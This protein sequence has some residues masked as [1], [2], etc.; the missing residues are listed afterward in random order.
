MTRLSH[1][2]S[3]LYIFLI[4]GKCG[5]KYLFN[6]NS[7]KLVINIT[8]SLANLNIIYIKIFQSICINSNLFTKEQIDYLNK[9]TDNV[10]YSS[11][12]RVQFL[13]DFSDKNLE[14]TN[15]NPINSGTMALVYKGKLNGKDIVVKVLRNNIREKLITSLDEI[16]LLC[17]ILSYI[18]IIKNL[19]LGRIMKRNRD[20]ILNQTNFK[21]EVNNIKMFKSYY[22][23]SDILIVPEVYEEFTNRNP[24]II[25]MEY[26]NGLKLQEIKSSD[27]IEF[28]KLLISIN[29][30]ST[31]FYRVIHGDPHI[32]NIFF[33]E[34]PK[35]IAYVDFGIVT[36]ITKEEQNQIYCFLN[37]L[38]NIKNYSEAADIFLSLCEPKNIL[39][40]MSL[41]TKNHIRNQLE[42]ICIK[43][44]QTNISTELIYVLNRLLEQYKLY[45]SDCFN[46]ILMGLSIMES[47]SI[48][49]LGK[50]KEKYY[51]EV[52]QSTL[53]LPFYIPE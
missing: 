40:K 41:N 15:I 52:I 44:A 49:M 38:Y 16:E 42:Q 27:K 31:L 12:D 4:L 1:I 25:V 53:N 20:V 3:I 21:Q 10:P 24:N 11:C 30:S 29:I 6:R 18:P 48:D 33:L 51:N 5:I 2:F 22:K 7:L 43:F 28:C 8:N 32:G 50:N 14:I 23:N 9:Y 39:D 46:Q 13:Q 17:I 37:Q 26:I 35:R 19:Q 34:E 36:I 47:I 45:L